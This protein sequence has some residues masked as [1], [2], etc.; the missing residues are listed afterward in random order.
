MKRLLIAMAIV[1]ALPGRAYALECADFWTWVE[2]GCREL[3]DTYQNGENTLILSG[4]SYHLPSTY[5]P[6]NRAQLNSNA[7]GIGAARA[8]EDAN[9]N[10]HMVYFYAFEDS[11]RT[12][13]VQPRL[14]VG[15]LLGRPRRAAGGP[16]LDGAHRAATRHRERHGRSPR[17]C[18]SRCCDTRRPI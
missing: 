12:A 7:W 13:Q 1:L 18:R 17:R 11:H 10:T 5:T 15:N 16:G 9:G 4:Y 2:T 3:A 8:V 6:E 14:L